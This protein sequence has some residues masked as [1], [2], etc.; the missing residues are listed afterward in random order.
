MAGKSSETQLGSAWVL[1]ISTGETFDTQR[2]VQTCLERHFVIRA[3]EQWN[4]ITCNTGAIY[5][6]VDGRSEYVIFYD[7]QDQRCRGALI[8]SN[9][10]VQRAN[11]SPRLND[12]ETTWVK[13]KVLGNE[14]HALY[15]K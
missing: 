5:G 14:T 7:N 15:D 13:A 12:D 10:L 4:G 3:K 6:A 2:N 1:T 11:W 8:M 9:A